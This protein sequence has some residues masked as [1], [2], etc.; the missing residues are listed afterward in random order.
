MGGPVTAI[1]LGEVDKSE[2][3]A[4]G[5]YGARKVLHASDPKLSKGVIQVFASVLAK[6][7]QDEQADILV[8]ANSSLGTP[9]AARVVV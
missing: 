8:I 5:K 6:A 4:L 1:A 9:V 7:M 3:E 2:L